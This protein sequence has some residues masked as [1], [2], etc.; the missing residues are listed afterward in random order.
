MSKAIQFRNRNNEKIYP[1]P[2]YPVGSIY[3]SINTT[4]PS[5]YFGGTWERVKGRFLLGADDSSYKIGGTGGAATVALTTSQMP[6]HAHT[7]GSMNI[8]GSFCTGSWM[9]RTQDVSGAFYLTGGGGV[10]AYRGD[11]RAIAAFDASR[12]WTG[13][14]SWAG[15]GTAHENRPPYYAV[16]YLMKV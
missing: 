8:T 1:C 7:R 6:S 10:G 11:N 4:N 3:I 9:G 5:T 13:E 15:S 2:Y 12:T 16:Y 14:T